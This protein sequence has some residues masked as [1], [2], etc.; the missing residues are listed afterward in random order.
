MDAS[1]TEKEAAVF[2]KL[3]ELITTNDEKLVE[4]IFLHSLVN[5]KR[6]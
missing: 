1:Y 2:E 5:R 6:I 4:I 3:L